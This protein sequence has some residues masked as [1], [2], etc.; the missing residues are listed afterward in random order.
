MS[1]SEHQPLYFGTDVNRQG[2]EFT[3]NSNG[4]ILDWHSATT[5]PDLVLLT[6]ITADIYSYSQDATK[7]KVHQIAP[8]T[9]QA[10]MAAVNKRYFVAA[11]Y[12]LLGP[13]DFQTFCLSLQKGIYPNAIAQIEASQAPGYYQPYLSDYHLGWEG[14]AAQLGIQ[15]YYVQIDTLNPDQVWFVPLPTTSGG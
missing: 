10:A 11:N 6:G 13:N 1:Y 2:L 7:L 8:S 5:N 15:G 4:L 14:L 3:V 9:I 12:Y